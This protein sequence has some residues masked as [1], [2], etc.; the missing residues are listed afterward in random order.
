MDDESGTPMC[1]GCATDAL[2]SG[3]FYTNDDDA[4]DADDTEE[5]AD[6]E[7]Q[8]PEEGDY[9]TSDHVHF[10]VDGKLVLTVPG[11]EEGDHVAALKAHMEQEGYWPNAWF[12]SDHGNAH[13]I[14][15]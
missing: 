11:G 9:T 7:P 12:I 14:E 8:E 13:R 10:Y 6:S 1:D 2:E 5:E 4:D 15:L 3:V